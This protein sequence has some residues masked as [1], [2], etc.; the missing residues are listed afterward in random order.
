MMV[1]KSRAAVDAPA[2]VAAETR[3]FSHW[4]AAAGALRPWLLVQGRN[5]NNRAVFTALDV[6]A[7]VEPG[8][9]RAG[10]GSDGSLVAAK[11][12]RSPIVVQIVFHRRVRQ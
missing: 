2:V 6:C 8:K 9:V 1:V 5:E 11:R 4:P 10:L 12:L 7:W 3:P